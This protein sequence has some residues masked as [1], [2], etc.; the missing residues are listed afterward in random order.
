MIG[1]EVMPHELAFRP[2]M[3]SFWVAFGV[4]P[5]EVFGLRYYILL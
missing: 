4:E 5:S 3:V 1:W 2:G